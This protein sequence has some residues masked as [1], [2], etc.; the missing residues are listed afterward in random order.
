MV[1]A[2][3]RFALG[4]A[5]C[6]HQS[7]ARHLAGN[8]KLCFWNVLK[9]ANDPCAALAVLPNPVRLFVTSFSAPCSTGVPYTTLIYD[10]ANPVNFTSLLSA[11]NGDGRFR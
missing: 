9:T 1:S 3:V 5:Y 6:L 7:A 10:A 11:T 2:G 8:A 4:L